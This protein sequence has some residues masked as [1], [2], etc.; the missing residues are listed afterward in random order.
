[1]HQ[2]PRIETS[3]HSSFVVSSV[4]ESQNMKISWT[5]YLGT[6]SQEF[7]L[8]FKNQILKLKI[9]LV[10]YYHGSDVSEQLSWFQPSGPLVSFPELGEGVRQCSHPWDSWPRAA[11]SLLG[12]SL[13][14]LSAGSLSS[15][16]G[17]LQRS[18]ECLPNM[19]QVLLPTW[20]LLITKSSQDQNKRNVTTDPQLHQSAFFYVV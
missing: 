3:C 13:Q 9:K 17:P 18:L 19:T 6:S 15:P 2:S 16:H 8:Y 1:M 14:C 10:I 12:D 11:G 5:S 4:Q 20:C 7:C